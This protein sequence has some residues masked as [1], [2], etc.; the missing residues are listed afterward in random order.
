[1]N[2]TDIIDIE[3]S[4]LNCSICLKDNILQ[5]EKCLT[6][7]NHSFCN[8]CLDEWFD[9]GSDACPLCRQKIT[10]FN[11]NNIT[12]RLV[13]RGPSNPNINDQR[14]MRT[15]IHT[16]TGMKHFQ[17]LFFTSM[18]ALVSVTNSYFNKVHQNNLLRE[19]YLLCDNNSS[20]LE[21]QMQT[22]ND[23]MVD[24]YDAYG[25]TLSQIDVLQEELHIC[26]YVDM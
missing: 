3:T 10:Y 6:N 20:H 9:T 5:E 22:Y 11:H 23:L 14:L 19:K 1:M 8:K 21:H 13:I 18:I 4:L 15:L 24:C 12:N 17:C 16:R 25:D 7:C 26:R 2:T